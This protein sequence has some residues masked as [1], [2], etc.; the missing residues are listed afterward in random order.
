MNFHFS[1]L[2]FDFSRPDSS[3]IQS[4]LDF[5]SFPTYNQDCSCF[6]L[7]F[8][9][10]TLFV[11]WK[12]CTI[13]FE[14]G[15]LA[16]GPCYAVCGCYPSMFHTSSCLLWAVSTP[17]SLCLAA[18]AMFQ[19][20]QFSKWLYQHILMFSFSS[21]YCKLCPCSFLFVSIVWI[22]H[23]GC[24]F[25]PWEYWIHLFFVMENIFG[26]NALPVI[27]PLSTDS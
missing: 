20:F 2:D 21:F 11:S 3:K 18:M 14:G 27:G 9:Y 22:V 19:T 8:Y 16:M 10:H 13:G 15:C 24:A 1:D 7:G 26:V 6:Y 12:I 25:H 17:L 23:V 4:F 5:S